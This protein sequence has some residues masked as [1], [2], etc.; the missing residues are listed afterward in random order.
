M[1][2]KFFLAP[3]ARWQGR[4][5]TGQPCVGGSL[6]TYQAGSIIPKA[7]F[8]D[9]F[10]TNPNTNPVILDGKG[11]ANIYWAN[12]DLYYI[13]LYD[14]N[15]FL[16]YSQDNYPDVD[17]EQPVD[18]TDLNPINFARNAQFYWWNNTTDFPNATQSVSNSDYIADDWLF[19]RNNLNA[20]IELKQV[21]F[22]IGQSVV[23]NNPVA[24]FEYICTNAGAGGETFKY[25]AQRYNSVQTLAGQTVTVA[26]WAKASAPNTA[27]NCTL[28]QS[29]G[30]GGS[31]NPDQDNLA[32]TANLTTTWA[33]YSGTVTLQAVNPPIGTNG[34]D[35]LIMKFNLPLNSN[36]TIDIANVQLQLPATAN[37]FPYLPNNNTF[38]QLDTRV[39]DAVWLTGD[40]KA[41][42]R[43]SA[44]QPDPGWLYMDD[45]SIGSPSSGA[46]HAGLFTKALYELLWNN[47]SNTYAPVNTGRGASAEA[48]Y[49]A[50][51]L[52]TLMRVLGRA[53]SSTGI[54]SSG[55]S[56]TNWALGQTTGEE[57][58]TLTTNEMPAHTH[59][60]GFNIPNNSVLASGG[61][62][63]STN[64]NTTTTSS[65]GGGAAHNTIQP[66]VYLNYVIKL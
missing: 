64:Q 54:P 60:F 27:L 14:V 32:V 49:N 39:T 24:Y 4:D 11:E 40:V 63:N 36:V 58:H 6:F 41:T 50:G 51:K 1:A 38:K 23:P 29:Y 35:A 20:T 55:G 59:Q 13:E 42:F 30:T 16:V 3:N 57:N 65:T 44:N 56:G 5:Q 43:S 15:G 25:L 62:F 7:T 37:S 46:T 26:F 47:V 53:M 10:G 2:T 21:L 22:T 19:F 61:G 48:D 52:M 33:Q 28:T 34:D 9:P 18:T 8:Q 12:D 45:T 66:T 31:P 17:F